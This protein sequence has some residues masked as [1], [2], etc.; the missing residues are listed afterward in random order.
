MLT[1]NCLVTSDP[2]ADSSCPAGL[3]DGYFM[4]QE[5]DDV[6]CIA[7]S[8]PRADFVWLDIE[9]PTGPTVVRD[10]ILINREDCCP[11]NLI[12]SDFYVGFNSMPNW[13]N[14]RCNVFPI[15]S[16]VYDCGGKIGTHLGILKKA[17]EARL[18]VS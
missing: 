15:K 11:D 7:S 18:G 2:V 4:K 14:P 8:G 10:V 12:G 6:H 17:P 5:V 13:R 1:P 9:F 3:V 16:G